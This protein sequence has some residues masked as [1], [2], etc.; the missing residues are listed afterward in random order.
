M[1]TTTGILAI[2][3][4]LRSASHNTA[5]LRAAAALSPSGVE[6]S[7]FDGLA[8]LPPYSEELD[9]G[10]APDPVRELR[11]AITRAD[12]VLFATPE[13]NRSIPGQLKNVLDW[14]SRPYPFNSLYDKP[15]AIIAG[16]PGRFGAAW[17]QGDLRSILEAIGARVI[18]QSL[19]IPRVHEAFDRH[20]RL[21]DPGTRGQ[22]AEIIRLLA[23]DARRGPAG[24]AA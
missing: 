14:A 13:Y 1:T 19:S 24:L 7:R 21:V 17:A 6:V 23:A 20:G 15:V 8:K 10:P 3:G 22:L 9:V 5:L 4:S 16:S 2:S 12:A 11:E 18:T